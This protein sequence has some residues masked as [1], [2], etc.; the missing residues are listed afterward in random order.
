MSTVCPRCG[1]AR[2]ANEVAPESEC[3]RCGIIYAK[4][5]AAQERLAKQNADP[6]GVA[7]YTPGPVSSGP[8]AMPGSGRPPAAP[9]RTSAAPEP[10]GG[11]RLSHLI[12]VIAVIALVGVVALTRRGAG[13]SGGGNA[14]ASIGYDIRGTYAGQYVEEVT[15]RDGKSYQAQYDVALTIGESYTVKEITWTDFASSLA[16]H[17][18]TWTG[19]A[20][21]EFVER[22]RESP[23]MAFSDPPYGNYS[24]LRIGDGTITIDMKRDFSDNLVHLSTEL[25]I[26]DR[27]RGQEPVP[28]G[29]GVFRRLK[30]E[31]A[32]EAI[33]T[34]GL[35]R[36]GT[37]EIPTE[38][39]EYKFPSSAATRVLKGFL[40]GDMRPGGKRIDLS[41]PIEGV[42]IKNT[43]VDG[44]PLPL[45]LSLLK[46]RVRLETGV[47]YDWGKIEGEEL[48]S[49]DIMP[50]SSA[51]L[52]F[53][54]GVTWEARVR[55]YKD[56]RARVAIPGRPTEFEIEKVASEAAAN[57]RF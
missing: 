10:S 52:T 38:G 13:G 45:E 4:F 47:S 46:V 49:I 32:I 33:C 9:P 3:P 27:R 1:Y 39:L 35:P 23:A 2:T 21:C 56:G 44:Y 8:A 24:L 48:R 55:F 14:G 29:D 36:L 12:I 5:L 6:A 31:K 57:L 11:I 22:R 53:R 34:G 28:P 30:E 7:R 50:E 20:S 41:S 18:V 37:V 40:S 19:P 51:S 16:K 43:P 15:E 25:P 42:D 17:E 26:P 54:E